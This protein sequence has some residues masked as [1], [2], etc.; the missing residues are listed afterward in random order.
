[1]LQ[2]ISIL[3]DN[4]VISRSMMPL[5]DP[6]PTIQR[7]RSNSNSVIAIKE[8]DLIFDRSSQELRR[9]IIRTWP[10]EANDVWQLFRQFVFH[11]LRWFGI[12]DIEQEISVLDANHGAD[13]FRNKLIY[14]LSEEETT[15][16]MRI[17]PSVPAKD[18]L[19]SHR[20]L[21]AKETWQDQQ[22]DIIGAQ[23]GEVKTSDLGE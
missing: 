10:V 8:W 6:G 18:G 20:T 16:I 21:T 1:M 7:A 4:D 19:S 23:P 13:N 22:Y 5:I 2:G 15:R 9:Y 11:K 17:L 14:K 3:L 12:E